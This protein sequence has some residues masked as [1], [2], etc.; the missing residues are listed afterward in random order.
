MKAKQEDKL[1]R[2]K[3]KREQD[4]EEQVRSAQ[5]AAD[6]AKKIAMNNEIPSKI[7]TMYGAQGTLPKQ[8]V[9]P[10][11]PPK[12]GVPQAKSSIDDRA[13]FAAAES[14]HNKV[15]PVKQRPCG[16]PSRHQPAPPKL[17]AKKSYRASGYTP[18]PSLYLP[19]Q[20]RLCYS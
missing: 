19:N 4:K 14:P 15:G 8:S 7:N 13:L 12:K 2:V 16:Q 9:S 6:A 11:I 20:T 18:P 1:R 10:K 5:L 3:N 17:T